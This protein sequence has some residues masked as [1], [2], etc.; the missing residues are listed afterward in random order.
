MLPPMRQGKVK[1]GVRISGEEDVGSDEDR[2]E[3]DVGLSDSEE[4]SGKGD[5]TTLSLASP[6]DANSWY[7]VNV[8]VSYLFNSISKHIRLQINCQNLNSPT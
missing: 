8:Q 2:S 7:Y 5:S 6:N 1:L 3:S 4:N